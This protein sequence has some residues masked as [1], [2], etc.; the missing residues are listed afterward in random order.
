MLTECTNIVINYTK[1]SYIISKWYYSKQTFGIG[2]EFM[3]YRITH[4][5]LVKNS[6]QITSISNLFS[7][8][9]CYDITQYKSAIGITFSWKQALRKWEC[10]TNL[11][12]ETTDLFYQ[13]SKSIEMIH[14]WLKKHYPYYYFP[15]A[16]MDICSEELI[17]IPLFQLDH[18]QEHLRQ[19]PR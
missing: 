4:F 2:K 11:I 9:R 10:F 14:I 15:N 3:A 19:E 12:Q 1:I 8:Y 16:I 13:S 5:T 7:I 18:L 17:D 6:V